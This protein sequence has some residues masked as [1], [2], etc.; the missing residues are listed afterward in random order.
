VNEKRGRHGE[1]TFPTFYRLNS[2]AALTREFTAAGFVPA[3]FEHIEVRPN[4]LTGSAVTFAMG[5]A[6]ERVVNASEALSA[7]R[8][9]IIGTFRKPARPGASHAC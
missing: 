4:Y 7:L 8:V 6:Y 2:R 5:V 1:D 3:G 9:N